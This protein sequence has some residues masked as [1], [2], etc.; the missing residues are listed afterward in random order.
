M[1]GACTITVI[2]EAWLGC[3]RLRN[4]LLASPARHTYE[5]ASGEMVPAKR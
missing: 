1:D 4:R 2:E 5:G 3:R